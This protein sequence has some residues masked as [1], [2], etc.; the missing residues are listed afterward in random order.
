MPL[1]LFTLLSLPPSSP[2]LYLNFIV[3]AR[4][5]LSTK[6]RTKCSCLLRKNSPLAEFPETRF[7]SRRFSEASPRPARTGALAV[8]A[9]SL[10]S[11][12]RLAYSN[13]FTVISPPTLSSSVPVRRYHLLMHSLYPAASPYPGYLRRASVFSLSRYSPLHSRVP[14]TARAPT[15]FH[16]PTRPNTPALYLECCLPRLRRPTGRLLTFSVRRT[17]YYL[18]CTTSPGAQLGTPRALSPSSPSAATA[19][20]LGPMLSVAPLCIAALAQH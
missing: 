9:R 1:I 18:C 20:L 19:S 3:F 6:C 14:G 11:F 8:L 17:S 4:A 15:S 10:F 7:V 13:R 5:A 12:S 16:A 2:S